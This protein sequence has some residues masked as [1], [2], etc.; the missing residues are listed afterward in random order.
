[1]DIDIEKLF[2]RMET[3]P[4]G[5]EADALKDPE[6]RDM[7]QAAA[8]VADIV[9]TV[10]FEATISLLAQY[11]RFPT[12]QDELRDLSRRLRVS[13]EFAVEIADEVAAALG[14]AKER[15]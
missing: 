1:M 4:E 14:L 7:M 5:L 6:L 11:A 15:N 8:D 12:V 13:S 2:E 9:E 3:D 10:G